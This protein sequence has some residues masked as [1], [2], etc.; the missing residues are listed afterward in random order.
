MVDF[1]VLCNKNI[2]MILVG[3]QQ[4]TCICVMTEFVIGTNSPSCELCL[5]SKAA[6]VHVRPAQ[7]CTENGISICMYS[8][9]EVAWLA[10][11]FWHSSTCMWFRI[12][13]KIFSIGGLCISAGGFAFFARVLDI[14]KLSKI[15]LIYS[16][17]RSNLGGLGVFL[18]RDK[19]T[20]LVWLHQ[21]WRLDVSSDQ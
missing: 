15:S 19:P 9:V 21:Q 12:A 10:Q 8:A 1:Y 20:G 16:V 18:G 13:A 4:P 14:I 5:L 7:S 3:Y 17:S 11:N 2:L 6:F